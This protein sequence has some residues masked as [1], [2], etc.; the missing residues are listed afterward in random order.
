[1]NVHDIV[2]KYL[3]DN[4]YDGL[5]TDECGCHIDDLMPCCQE[6]II[7]CEPGYAMS[8]EEA[9]LRGHCI[10]ESCDE[11]ISA[12][13][14]LTPK[15]LVGIMYEVAYLEEILGD[16]DEYVMNRI[17]EIRREEH[18][19]NRVLSEAVPSVSGDDKAGGESH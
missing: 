15:Q 11:I 19:R 4:G 12:E 13:K 3:E 9:K 6:G 18:D 8:V 7:S 1:M 10:T 14:P 2:K 5:C 16:A 17:I